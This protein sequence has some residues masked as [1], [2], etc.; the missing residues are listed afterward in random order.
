MY[1]HEFI[2]HTCFGLFFSQPPVLSR[3]L[4]HFPCLLSSCHCCLVRVSRRGCSV[5]VRHDK[6]LLIRYAMVIALRPQ[7]PK[8]IR[9]GWS[10]YTDT[11]EP[12]EIMEE[13]SEPPEQSCL[14]RWTEKIASLTLIWSKWGS[15]PI[16]NLICSQSL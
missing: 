9:A 3:S 4:P 1:H 11:S 7:T 16:P 13:Y 10:H 12:A 8:H 14:L 2:T 5:S 15:N 6:E